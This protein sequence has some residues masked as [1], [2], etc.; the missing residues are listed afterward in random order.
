M[1]IVVGFVA[2]VGSDGGRLALL[3]GLVLASLGGL[4]T[5]LREH[6]A[7]FRSHS[8]VLAG[9]PAVLVAGGLFFGRAPWAAVV[10]GVGA[11]LR[12]AFWWS[13][14][15]SGAGRAD[16]RSAEARLRG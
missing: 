6:F 14:R 16:C 15:R 12:R 1:L 10:G 7:G 11:H 13:G 3:C 9:L 5:A 8:S 4:D 2:G